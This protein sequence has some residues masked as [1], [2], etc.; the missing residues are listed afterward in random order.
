M[1]VIH[2]DYVSCVEDKDGNMIAFGVAI[3][4]MGTALQKPADTSCPSVGTTSSRPFAATTASN[5]C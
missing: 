1:D 4:Y 5:C 3:P 2:P